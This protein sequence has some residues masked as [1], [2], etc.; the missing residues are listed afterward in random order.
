MKNLEKLVIGVFSLIDFRVALD[1]SISWNE[2]KKLDQGNWIS[3]QINKQ[4]QKKRT[5]WKAFG[6]NL[7]WGDSEDAY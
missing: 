4:K 7:H 5:A 2:K 6:S 3:K 1:S